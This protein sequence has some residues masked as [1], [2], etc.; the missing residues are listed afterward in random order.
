MQKAFAL[1]GDKDPVVEKV[2]V[3]PF[4]WVLALG[5]V[6]LMAIVSYTRYLRI[7]EKHEKL[8]KETKKA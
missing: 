8:E 4:Q 3:G 2:G 7:L 5:V 1:E 6:I